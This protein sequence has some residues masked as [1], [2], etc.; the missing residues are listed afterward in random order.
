[1]PKRNLITDIK[2]AK[3]LLSAKVFVVDI[4]T[5]TQ[6]PDHIAY[7][8]MAVEFSNGDLTW[9]ADTYGKTYVADIT[10]VSFFVPGHDPV[11]LDLRG[12]PEKTV[13]FIRRVFDRTGYTVIA[14]NAVFDLR[15]LGGHLGFTLKRGVKVWDTMVMSSTLLLGEAERQKAAGQLNLEFQVRQFGLIDNDDDREFYSFMKQHRSGLSKLHKSL[16]TLP[17]DHVAWRFTQTGFPRFENLDLPDAT[18]DEYMKVLSGRSQSELS[19]FFDISEKEKE[20]I[21]QY[22]AMDTIYPYQLYEIHQDLVRR[23]PVENVVK[24]KTVDPNHPEFN[25]VIPKWESLPEIIDYETQIS[26][27]SANQAIIGIDLDIP[28][29]K[30]KWQEWW[31]IYLEERQEA[32]AISDPSD[33]YAGWLDLTQFFL[34]YSMVLNSIRGEGQYNDIS[35]WAHFNP[36]PQANLREVLRSQLQFTTDIEDSDEIESLRDFWTDWLL[37]LTAETK[38]G[39]AHKVLQTGNPVPKLDMLAWVRDSCFADYDTNLA[40]FLAQTKLN[41]YRHLFTSNVVI[42]DEKIVGSELWQRYHLFVACQIQLPTS[43][44]IRDEPALVTN[45]FRELMLALE[46]AVKADPSITIDEQG[47]AIRSNTFALSKDAMAYYTQREKDNDSP[48]YS[49]YK[50]MSQARYDYDRATE[51]LLHASRDGKIHS[52][53]TRAAKTHR[54]TSQTPNLQNNNMD[55]FR[56][57][58]KAPDDDYCLVEVDYSNAENKMGA[59]IAQDDA[60]ALATEGKDFHSAMAEKY[61][62]GEWEA[63]KAA[64]DREKLKELRT[65]SKGPTFAIPYGAGAGKIM[66]LIGSTYEE[67]DALIKARR[68]AFP[69]VERAKQTGADNCIARWNAGLNPAY[70]PLWTGNRVIVGQYIDRRTHQAKLSLYR[71]WNYRQQGGVGEMTARAQVEIEEMLETEGYLTFMILNVHD[72]LI[73]AVKISEWP[74]VVQKIIQIMCRQFPLEKCMMTTPMIHFVTEVGPENAQK[75]GYRHGR[76]YPLPLDTFVNQWGE[77]RLPD[78]ELEKPPE[79]REAPSWVGPVHL[80]WTLEKEMAEQK[81]ARA[82]LFM[83]NQMGATVTTE[84]VGAEWYELSDMLRELETLAGEMVMVLRGMSDLRKPRTIRYVTEDNNVK[85]IGP[86][87]FAEHMLAISALLQRGQVP[88]DYAQVQVPVNTFIDFGIKLSRLGNLLEEWK[89]ANGKLPDAE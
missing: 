31:D 62:S 51:L 64:G 65:R 79:K 40:V 52:V 14:H 66:T 19:Q 89:A 88:D 30:Q 18:L 74:D 34:W 12:Y 46:D 15:S 87:A 39:Q 27:I 71:N 77:H 54:Y 63:A 85:V 76:E 75:W 9:P 10:D 41:W 61:W 44:E 2:D 42:P 72:S 35:K 56:G 81:A 26:R 38:R 50:R 37:D 43:L 20:I 33:P 48:N 17:P 22:V 29:A 8:P 84:A 78:S 59:A 83:M 7:G 47:L 73:L 36:Y 24:V 32:L 1:M 70:V 4:E 55:T 5:D 21:A 28:Y 45:K 60:F 23:L 69:Q 67:A 68:A 3:F 49:H 80:G 57:F 13:N 16:M 86:L 25:R 11:V 58:F 53:I 6:E 82:Q